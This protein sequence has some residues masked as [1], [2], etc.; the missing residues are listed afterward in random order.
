MKR[1]PGATYDYYY[2]AMKVTQ[3]QPNCEKYK[4]GGKHLDLRAPVYHVV[5][6][7]IFCLKKFVSIL[8]GMSN[9]PQIQICNLKNILPI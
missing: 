3:H 8:E 7:E 4:P 9:F 2:E 1:R 5:A 6:D